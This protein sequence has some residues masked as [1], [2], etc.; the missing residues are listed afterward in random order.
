MAEYISFQPS[1]FYNTKLYT[2]TGV[3]NAITGVGFQPDFTWIKNR[4]AADNHILTDAATGATK[5]MSSNITTALTTNAESLKSFDSD[6]FT[7]GTYGDVNTNTED[8]VSWNWKAGT[9]TG[10]SGGTITP[11]A[12]SINT[13]SG[14]GVYAY[15]GTGS[16]A[17]IA[18]GLGVAPTFM[19]V[20][21]L[22]STDSWRVYHSGIGP[23]KYMTLN[24]TAAETTEA[25]IWNS[26]APDA[27]V[28]SIGTDS[29]TN[30]ST[31]TY[32]AY[33]FAPIK[34]FSAFN[35]YQGQADANGP[36]CYTGF[37]PAM[38]I[39]KKSGSGSAA[40]WQLANTQMSSA[41]GANVINRQ[42]LPDTADTP[43]TENSVDLLSTGFKIRNGA[44][45]MNQNLQPFIYA[46]F[47][48]FPT[49]SSNDVPTVAR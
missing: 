10:L 39:F 38:V 33:V 7:V 24:S 8:Y 48:E 15:T 2:G 46:A 29:S 12:Y 49:V 5:Y 4:D 44:A 36:F 16:N 14:F 18:H 1:D 41:G 43:Q 6:G 42:M 22:N 26:T 20:K 32:I 37:R 13:T 47:A 21:R 40:N 30:T 31:N 9:T 23:T 28:F 25:T 11:S 45:H 19:M 35:M 34:G 17:T 3:S 27:T